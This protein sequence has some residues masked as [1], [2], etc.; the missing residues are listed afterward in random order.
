M[1]RIGFVLLSIILVTLCLCLG[2]CSGPKRPDPT[3][4]KKKHEEVTQKVGQAK[5]HF[6]AANVKL[7]EAKTSNKKAEVAVGEA[8][9]WVTLI[10]PTL[11]DLVIKVPPELKAEVEL[12]VVRMD[13]LSAEIRV[14]VS[15]IAETGVAVTAAVSEQANGLLRITDV[16]KG[17]ADINTKYG[18]ELFAD[19]DKMS[20]YADDVTRQRNK[21]LG[22]MAAGLAIAAAIATTRFVK[23]TIPATYSIPVVA[24]AVV[25]TAVM[26]W[27]RFKT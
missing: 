4:L 21:I 24:F 15:G 11:Q 25:Y 19:M 17:M 16:E 10:V 2:G 14:A 6:A 22:L 1:G 8:N 26:L 3:V 20:D 7:R 12:M 27:G 9:K 13:S 18:P 5:A 23:T